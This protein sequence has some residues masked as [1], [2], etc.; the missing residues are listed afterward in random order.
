MEN[1]VV[2]F[3]E[4]PLVIA[5]ANSVRLLKQRKVGHD[6]KERLTWALRPTVTWLVSMAARRLSEAKHV[7][8]WVI[9]LSF[10]KRLTAG[11]VLVLLLLRA[12]LSIIRR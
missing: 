12:I 5:G 1:G 11:H 6:A 4:Q 8:T 7:S 3:A 10:K 9:T 2:G